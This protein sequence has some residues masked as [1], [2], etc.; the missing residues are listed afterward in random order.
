MIPVFIFSFSS[1]RDSEASPWGEANPK[2][3]T[4]MIKVPLSFSYFVYIIKG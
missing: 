4:G 1:L 3:N 2:I